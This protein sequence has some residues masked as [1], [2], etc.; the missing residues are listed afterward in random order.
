[1]IFWF[2]NRLPEFRGKAHD[3]N[4]DARARD[5]PALDEAGGWKGRR[6]GGHSTSVHSIRTRSPG[7]FAVLQVNL[8]GADEAGGTDVTRAAGMIAGAGAGLTGRARDEASCGAGR[9]IGFGLT[10]SCAIGGTGACS[11]GSTARGA[12]CTATITG[13]G[14]GDERQGVHELSRVKAS[15]VGRVIVSAVGIDCMQPESA[16]PKKHTAAR[17]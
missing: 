2:I 7:T 9:A 5:P 12:F 11:T 14:S 1:M 8:G 6:S 17:F 4:D 3:S 13:G 10:G 15:M 16:K